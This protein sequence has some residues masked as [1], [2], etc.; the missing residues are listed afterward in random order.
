M[1]NTMK[2]KKTK[3][4]ALHQCIASFV[5][6]ICLLLIAPLTT[7]HA[8]SS[9]RATYST[10]IPLVPL[11]YTSH[12]GFTDGNNQ[13]SG[14]PCNPDAKS[15]AADEC[16]TNFLWYLRGLFRLMVALSVALAV[17]YIAY[18]GFQYVLSATEMGKTDGKEII[19]R[20]LTGLIV[21]LCS[22][23]IIYTINPELVTLQFSADKIKSSELENSSLFLSDPVTLGEVEAKKLKY[24]DDREKLNEK[25]KALDG[26]LATYDTS[27]F[28][29]PKV[30]AEY[31]ALL[32]EKRELNRQEAGLI[33]GR[34]SVLR[35]EAELSRKQILSDIANAK[36]PDIAKEKA[37]A[38]MK[39]FNETYNEAA[40]DARL[41]GGGEEKQ[42]AAEKDVLTAMIAKAIDCRQRFPTNSAQRSTGKIKEGYLWD[43]E[44]METYYPYD[45]CVGAK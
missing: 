44:E 32:A 36:S 29:D 30:L 24:R 20:S 14:I 15:G 4:G 8:A 6:A 23:L 33:S 41:L 16:R 27:D 39:E 42:L 25:K 28:K 38:V 9:D 19:K 1:R 11:P 37:A 12:A 18:G 5:I 40:R 21:V 3:K 7:T 10:Y 31:D 45:E 17:V 13:D 26:K 35:Q 34:V 2:S 43:S 22:Y